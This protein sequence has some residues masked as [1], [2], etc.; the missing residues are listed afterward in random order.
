MKLLVIF[1]ALCVAISLLKDR[2]KTMQAFKKALKKFEKMVPP[3]LVVIIVC[4]D[5]ALFSVR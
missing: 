1:T 5:S 4:V 2:K 3:F